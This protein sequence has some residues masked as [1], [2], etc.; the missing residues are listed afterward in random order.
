MIWKEEADFF[1]VKPL[2]EVIQLFIFLWIKSG[3]KK[4][5][6]LTKTAEALL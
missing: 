2:K 5:E 6:D 1:L 3:N 4:C